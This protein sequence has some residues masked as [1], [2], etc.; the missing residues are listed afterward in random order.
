A[1]RP[2]PARAAAVRRGRDAP[3]P[4]AIP[5]QAAGGIRTNAI[6][7]VIESPRLYRRFIPLRGLSNEKGSEVFP[8]RSGAGGSNPEPPRFCRGALGEGFEL[9]A[10][11]PAVAMGEK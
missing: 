3:R 9:L 10:K 6:N 8:G 7:A 1:R 2:P 5:R 11:L 4:P